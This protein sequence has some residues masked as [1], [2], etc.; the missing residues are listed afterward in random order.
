MIMQTMC[1][2]TVI[3]LRMFFGFSEMSHIVHDFTIDGK[4]FIKHAKLT[5]QAHTIDL[6]S[7][8]VLP[9]NAP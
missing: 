1:C 8:E 2:K 7:S 9:M 6:V 3:S 4:D 5:R